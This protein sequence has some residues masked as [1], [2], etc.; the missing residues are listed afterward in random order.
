MKQL[1][2]YSYEDAKEDCRGG[3][4]ALETSK[5][6]WLSI[7]KALKSIRNTMSEPC[8]L[9]IVYNDCEGCP[10][11]SWE[12]GDCLNEVEKIVDAYRDVDSL[13]GRLLD[14]LEGVEE[15]E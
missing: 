3:T 12:G 15:T 10:L 13:V 8:G 7:L 11:S 5:L 2:L 14:K 9:C 1:N 4:M 6:K